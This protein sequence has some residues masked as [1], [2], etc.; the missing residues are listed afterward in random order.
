MATS[1]PGDVLRQLHWRYAVKRFDP[2]RRIDDATW[3]VLEQSLVLAP[4]SFGLQPWKFVVVGTTALRQQ[5]RAA[6]WNQPQVT[7]ASH[8]VVIAGLRTTTTADVDRMIAAT[9]GVRGTTPEALAR[10]RQV[11]VDFVQNGCAAADLAAWNARQA[12]IAL[13]QFLTAAAMLGVDTSPL[14]G[15]DCA[16]YDRLLGLDGSRHTTLCGCAAGYR[17]ADDRG[18]TTPKMRYPATE[19]I[20]RR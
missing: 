9:A 13:G 20:E 18:A 5:L 2:A 4:S 12:Y 1:S 15:I 16:A 8:Y 14:E 7:D 3:A 11:I 19:I 6:S 17:A 10:Y